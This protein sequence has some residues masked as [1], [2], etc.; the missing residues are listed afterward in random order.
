MKEEKT[1]K[2]PSQDSWNPTQYDKFKAERSQPFYDLQEMVEGRK[3]MTI[4]DLGCGTGELTKHLHQKLDAK[5][6][7][8]T[9]NSESMLLK[10]KNHSMAGLD[11]RNADIANFHEDQAYD[12]IFA[13]ASLQWCPNHAD[14]WRR[15]RNGLR[16][17]GQIAIQ[18][19]MNH[20]YAT[21]TVAYDLAKEWEEKGLL[22][23]TP[24]D[25]RL[26][27]PEQ[28]AE[29]LF[30]LKFLRQKVFLRVYSHILDDRESV[31]EWVRGTLL[32]FYQ[33]ALGPEL[34]ARFLGEYRDRLFDV[35]PDSRPF[36]YPFKRI[37]MWASL[38]G[39]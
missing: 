29:L 15:L 27:T 2:I 3:E 9:D 21:H 26:L 25:A 23:K 16:P 18:M 5:T 22:T 32:T 28:Y 39:G 38:A 6:T 31:I 1:E 14:L 33:S 7:L 35:L 30:D 11:F 12:L 8:G 17:G 37:L 24:R 20:D 34:F 13:N 10:A 36:F 4:I 19:P